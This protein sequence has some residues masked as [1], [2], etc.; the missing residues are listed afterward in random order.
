[1]AY[2]GTGRESLCG[3]KV[4]SEEGSGERRD[5]KVSSNSLGPVKGIGFCFKGNKEF[6]AGRSCDQ[7]YLR[8]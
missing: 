3:R 7:S 1:M 6:E 2:P 8:K 4:E 5:G